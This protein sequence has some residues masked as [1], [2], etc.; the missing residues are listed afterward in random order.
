MTRQIAAA[1]G[2]HSQHLRELNKILFDTPSASLADSRNQDVGELIADHAHDLEL[3][4]RRL[5]HERRRAL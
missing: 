4:H 3:E 1:T 5:Y 2:T